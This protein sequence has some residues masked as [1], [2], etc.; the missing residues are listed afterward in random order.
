MRYVAFLRAIN[1]GTRRIKMADLRELYADLG[2]EDAATY[3]ATGNVIFDSVSLPDVALLESAFEERFGFFS[4]LFLRDERQIAS[5]LDRISW[6][7]GDGVVEVSFLE[8]RPD[9]DDARELEATAVAPEDIVVSDSEILF[10][11]E[12]KGMETTHKESTSMRIL[13]MKMTRRGVATVRQIN[14][15]FLT[16]LPEGTDS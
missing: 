9:P 8:S 11:R 4:K 1:T 12:G 16:E 7:D 3:I 10:L 13:G 2:Y 15:R 14:D 5:M 6:Q